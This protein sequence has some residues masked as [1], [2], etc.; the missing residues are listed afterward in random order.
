[1]INYQNCCVNSRIFAQKLK[2]P[3]KI[4]EL[5]ELILGLRVG[6]MHEEAMIRFSWPGSYHAL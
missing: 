4:F 5:C 6:K 3:E 1:M 2:I